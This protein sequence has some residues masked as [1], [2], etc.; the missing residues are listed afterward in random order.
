MIYKHLN[1]RN[2]QSFYHITIEQDEDGKH[3]TFHSRIHVNR[4]NTC[5]ITW[6]KE[7]TDFEILNDRDLITWVSRSY[8]EVTA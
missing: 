7:Y 4:E 2:L 8:G 5:P 6:C 3:V 1:G